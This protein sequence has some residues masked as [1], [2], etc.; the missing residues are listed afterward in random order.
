MVVTKWPLPEDEEHGDWIHLPEKNIRNN[1]IKNVRL[2]LAG[3]N[4]FNITSF[5]LWDPEMGG[6]GFNYPLQRVY[7]AD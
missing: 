5:K 1:R 6:E 4:L 7:S 2:Y 3:Q